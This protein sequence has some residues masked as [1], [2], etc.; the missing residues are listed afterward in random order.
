M[1]SYSHSMTKGSYS[2]YLTKGRVTGIMS[3]GDFSYKRG[4]LG[5]MVVLIYFF[6][7]T[8]YDTRGL[9]PIPPIGVLLDVPLIINT[10]FT[11]YI[12]HLGD[13]I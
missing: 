10:F 1:S 4:L 8:Q 6:W 7:G 9:N 12:N 11:K 3:Y 2:E 13:K 5:K